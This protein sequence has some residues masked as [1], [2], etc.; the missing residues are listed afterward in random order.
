MTNYNNNSNS[1]NTIINN[2]ITIAEIFVDDKNKLTK[3]AAFEQN[4][5]LGELRCL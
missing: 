2:N 4:N 1:N 3:Q 5:L